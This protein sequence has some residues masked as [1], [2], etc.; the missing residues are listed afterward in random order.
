MCKEFADG[1]PI[2]MSYEINGRLVQENDLCKNKSLTDEYNPMLGR[3]LFFKL[4]N[5]VGCPWG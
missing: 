3:V 2:R 1:P 5:E 4:V